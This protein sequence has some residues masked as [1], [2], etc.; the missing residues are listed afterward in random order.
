MPIISREYR[1]L[2]L[3]FTIHPN[4]KTINVLDSDQAIIRSVR[5]LLLTQYYEKPFHPEIGSDVTS[6]LFEP[7]DPEIQDALKDEI[8]RVINNFEPRVSMRRVDV[9]VDPDNNGV[10]VTLVFY[11]VGQARA[12]TVEIF[13]ER[14][15]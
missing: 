4:T 15:R 8:L 10:Y 7:A 1:D 13:L 12:K 5:N 14:N 11:I 6:Y 9:R 2:D 3:N